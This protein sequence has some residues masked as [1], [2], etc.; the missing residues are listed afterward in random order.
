MGKTY[1]H[2]KTYCCLLKN[3]EKVIVVYPE[4]MDN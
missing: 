4:K 2:S 3:Q 1:T